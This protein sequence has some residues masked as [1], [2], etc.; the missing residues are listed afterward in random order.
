MPV[1]CRPCIP[2]RASRSS[3]CFCRRC[4]PCRAP[5]ATSCIPGTSPQPGRLPV[6]REAPAANGL[7]RNFACISASPILAHASA[8]SSWR[9][10]IGR[11]DESRR[12][13]DNPPLVPRMRAV[14]TGQFLQLKMHVI[15]HNRGPVQW[16]CCVVM[17]TVVAQW[18]GVEAKPNKHTLFLPQKP[19][20]GVMNPEYQSALPQS[21][22]QNKVPTRPLQRKIQSQFHSRQQVESSPLALSPLSGSLHDELCTEYQRRGNNKITT[23]P[24]PTAAYSNHAPIWAKPHVP[25]TPPP[26]KVTKP[27]GDSLNHWTGNR[28]QIDWQ[29]AEERNSEFPLSLRDQLRREVIQ[30]LPNQTRWPPK[31]SSTHSCNQDCG[32]RAP[33][34]P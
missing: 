9:W 29:T 31:R 1:R 34:A 2:W 25:K 7:G 4:S 8:A 5:R 18:N 12:R 23:T 3:I 14:S 11:L 30:S 22:S 32:L 26:L 10:V 16:W 15:F 33:R 17:D 27:Q 28:I 21:R 19:T 20:L 6:Q 13:R 24:R